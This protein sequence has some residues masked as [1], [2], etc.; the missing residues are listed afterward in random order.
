MASLTYNEGALA[1]ADGSVDFLSDVIEC[2]FVKDSYTPDQDDDASVLAAA[3]IS[4]VTGY[5]EGFGGSGRKALGS[6]SITKD[7]ASNRIIYDAADPS[8]WT[9]GAGDTIGGMIIAKKGSV[10]DA[11]AVLLFF[12]ECDDTPTNGSD[13]DFAFD[14]AGIRYVQQ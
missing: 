12:I 5:N 1:L 7:D 3:E 6:K 14:A 8:T 4:G 2:I 13:I 9:I 11:T 10:S